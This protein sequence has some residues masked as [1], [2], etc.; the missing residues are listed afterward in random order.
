MYDELQLINH[1]LK[2]GEGSFLRKN[3]IDRT[4]FFSLKE[5]VDW[6]EDFHS[7]SGKVPSIETVSIEFEDFRPVVELE[8]LSY[9][10]KKVTENRAY[11]EYRPI[12]KKNAE[13]LASGNTI[14]ALWDMKNNIDNIVKTYS[15]KHTKYDWVKNALDRYDRYMEQH[16]KTGLAGLTTGIKGLDAITGGWR[17]D[18]LI[19]VT[20]RTNEGKS[21][22]GGFFAFMAWRSLMLAGIKDPVIYITTEMPELEIAYRLDT[23]KSHFSNRA[24]TEGTLNDPELYR[25]YLAE[26]QNK[27]SSFLILSQDSNGGRP[28]TPTDIRSII[29]TEKPALI[30]I[31]Q[32]YDLSDGTGEKDTRKRIINI[33]NAIREIN[34]ATMTPIILIAQAGREAAKSAK[35]DVLA[36]P[37]IHDIQESD[38]P[39][40]KATRVLTLRLIDNA[41]F[42]MTLRKN[43]GGKKNEDI[44]MDTDI[45]SGM[46]S[47]V[48]KEE[49]VF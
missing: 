18:D 11:A 15:T 16:G 41:I 21:L 19:L 35:K 40:Q 30:C 23:L 22:I 9:V 5:V 47:E 43:R 33:S 28:F 29:E 7:K 3:G 32:M 48:S 27:D 20:G 37:E 34:L 2:S 10:I 31:D 46:W 45:D 24:L 13:M 4:Y 42:K 44:F 8:S 39:A 6:V 1:W 25:E 26:L 38:N 14:E 17:A 36:T 49:T 12:L